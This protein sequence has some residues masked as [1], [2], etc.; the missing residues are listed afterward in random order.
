METAVKD[1]KLIG[2]LVKAVDILRC[3]EGR[4]EIGVSEIA[5]SLGFHKSTAFSL[6]TTLE[7]LGLLEKSGENHKYR[8][9]MELF[10]LGSM[11]SL[12]VRHLAR[13]D[14]ERLQEEVKETVHL[15]RRNDLYILFL[16]RFESSYAMKIYTVDAKP[17]QIYATAVGKAMLSTLR[18]D[19]LEI[20][21]RRMQFEKLTE[22]TISSPEEFIEEIRLIRKKGYAVDNEEYEDG[23]YC[24]GAPLLDWTGKAEYAISVSG[25][26]V[27]TAGDK[28]EHIVERVKETAAKISLKLGYKK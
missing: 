21:M 15:A 23:L 2:S 24:I 28:R 18:D 22:N 17:L 14:L 13:Y 8:L 9:G 27:R 1:A 4:G 20:L 11:V 10:R 6:I 25:P 16:E 12:N 7:R 19:E 3:F 26:K 5:S